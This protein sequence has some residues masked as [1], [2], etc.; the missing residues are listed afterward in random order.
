MHQFYFFKINIAELFHIP[1]TNHFRTNEKVFGQNTGWLFLD[2]A[3]S[4][5]VVSIY[6]VN[7]SVLTA[8]PDFTHQQKR[9]CVSS[10]VQ[11]ILMPPDI[12][13]QMTFCFVLSNCRQL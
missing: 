4:L 7:F 11:F 3:D 13:G 5:F 8:C 1:G 12:Q 6:L 10:T 9:N 2:A